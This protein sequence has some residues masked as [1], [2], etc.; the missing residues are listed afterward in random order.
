[1]VNNIDYI[2]GLKLI[3]N[4]NTDFS[5]KDISLYGDAGNAVRFV[6]LFSKET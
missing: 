4:E 5:R 6:Q 2:Y 1:M 3:D